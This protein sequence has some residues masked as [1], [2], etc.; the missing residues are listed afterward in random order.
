MDGRGQQVDAT[1]DENN[2]MSPDMWRTICQ[3]CEEFGS[4]IAYAT[5]AGPV[6]YREVLEKVQC[7]SVSLG[8]MLSEFDFEQCQPSFSVLMPNC[9]TH[10]DL[11]LAAAATRAKMVCLNHR[12]KLEELQV[13][14][15]RGTSP[16][17]YRQQQLW[18]SPWPGCLGKRQDSSNRLGV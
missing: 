7:L 10:V 9:P 16:S 18:R 14:F 13:L 17:P 12:L 6:T 2:N 3:S 11:F 1:P 15:E 5:S 4:N 8:Q